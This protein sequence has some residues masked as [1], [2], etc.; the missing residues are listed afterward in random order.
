MDL[1]DGDDDMVINSSVQLAHSPT[2]N[3]VENA[4]QG[5]EN[6]KRSQIVANSIVYNN[7]PQMY[8]NYYDQCYQ[9]TIATQHSISSAGK[10]L[11]YIVKLFDKM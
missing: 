5:N 9:Q 7:Q 6:S 2:T 10:Y 11:A 1:S 4:N 8:Q 3:F